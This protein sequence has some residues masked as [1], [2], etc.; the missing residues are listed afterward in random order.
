MDLKPEEA[1]IRGFS[2]GVAILGERI[3]ANKWGAI[4]RTVRTL[5]SARPTFAEDVYSDRGVGHAVS[6]FLEKVVGYRFYYPYNEREMKHTDTDFTT[7]THVPD[8]STV[9]VSESLSLAEAPAYLYR[10]G[11]QAVPAIKSDLEHGVPP[12]YLYF[13]W[14]C[15]EQMAVN[16]IYNVIPRDFPNRPELFAKG[17]DGQP[18]YDRRQ[19]C[20]KCF[21][22][23]EHFEIY[24]EQVKYMDRTGKKSYSARKGGRRVAEPHRV[25]VGP[26]DATWVDHDPRAQKWYQPERHPVGS[27]S[28]LYFNFIAK[29]AQ[30]VNEEWP[31][32][33][34][35]AMAQNNYAEAPSDR[36]ELPDNVNV[37]ACISKRSSLM[38]AQEAYEEYNNQFIDDWHR[39][40]DGDRRRLALWDYPS[41]PTKWTAIPVYAPHVIQRWYK[42]NRDKMAGTYVGGSHSYPISV[43]MSILWMRLLWNPDMDI[44]AFYRE[45]CSKM[46]G[47]GAE[48]MHEVIMRSAERYETVQWAERAGVSSIHGGA[49]HGEVFPE[50]VVRDIKKRFFN[51]WEKAKAAEDPVFAQRIEILYNEGGDHGMDAFFKASRAYHRRNL[52]R[53]PDELATTVFHETFE[54]GPDVTQETAF[55]GKGSLKLKGNG[56][57]VRRS[58]NVALEPNKKYTISAAMK[59]VGE[60]KNRKRNVL[61]GLFNRTADGTHSLARLHVHTNNDGEWHEDATTFVTGDEI[62]RI[63][64]FVRNNNSTGTVHLDELK[65]V[66][67][68][69]L[70]ATRVDEDGVNVDGQL[71]EAIWEKAR[72]YSLLEGVNP[73]NLRPQRNWWTNEFR[74]LFSEEALYVGVQVSG[75]GDV[76]ARASEPKDIYDDDHIS[77]IIDEGRGETPEGELPDV[78]DMK[79]PYAEKV[80]AEAKGRLYLSV[81]P[82]GVTDPAWLQAST[83]QEHSRMFSAEMRVPFDKIGIDPAEQDTLFIDVRRWVGPR[84]HL[85]DPP[86]RFVFAGNRERK[87][88]LT[89]E[90]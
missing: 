45:F 18:M 13:R 29:L 53:V 32:R 67:R 14:G 50:R 77:L 9:Q 17:E 81:N 63:I 22:E 25:L 82:D 28:D 10:D 33:K 36:V 26:S 41:R 90:K 79:I 89:L 85:A 66:T 87:I 71:N 84:P 49:A 73:L 88:E 69:P 86:I 47:P 61:V 56:G 8:V 2:N 37:F 4:F 44:E 57:K 70:T 31:G 68:K 6:L 15:S 39:K 27:Q 12:G 20:P 64:F 30:R 42:R 55:E 76:K 52:A 58:F 46:F 7:W 34:V 54:E 75:E 5:F 65:L 80:L 21:A 3:Q 78:G 35:S 1:V 60:F 38:N 24:I 16:H 19:G 62:G 59:M 40:L 43:P 23:P 83:A 51:A 48:D 11:V 74:V 72:K